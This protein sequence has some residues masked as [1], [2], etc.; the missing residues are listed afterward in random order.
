[1]N[2]SLKK[3]KTIKVLFNRNNSVI[4]LVKDN[5]Q[6]LF[7]IKKINSNTTSKDLTNEKSN[8]IIKKGNESYI[9]FEFKPELLTNPLFGPIYTPFSKE[10]NEIIS[11]KLKYACCSIFYGNIGIKEIMG[12]FIKFKINN[13]PIKKGLFINQIF[14][15]KLNIIN[16]KYENETYSIDISHGRKIYFSFK[17]NYTLIE[18]IDSDNIKDFLIYDEDINVNFDNINNFLLKEVIFLVF[19]TKK[20]YKNSI[21][22][23]V[24]KENKLF[25]NYKGS[26]I[27]NYNIN[28][29]QLDINEK[30]LVIIL[31]EK[32]K[33]FPLIDNYLIKN[34]I[35][36]DIKKQVKF[37][38]ISYKPSLNFED[39]KIIEKGN[40]KY[41][42]FLKDGNFSILTSDP[43]LLYNER[44]ISDTFENLD[45][46]FSYKVLSSDDL[47]IF[48]KN[49]KKAKI[50]RPNKFNV[51]KYET[52]QILDS[53]ISIDDIIE[54]K[55]YL[56]FCNTKDFL[57]IEM[58]KYNKKDNKYISIQKIIFYQY[59]SE[60]KDFLCLKL[61]LTEYKLIK[62]NTLCKMLKIK[63]NQLILKEGIKVWFFEIINDNIS[64][65]SVIKDDLE[66][67]PF[68]YKGK[69]LLTK[70]AN[71]LFDFK[72]KKSVATCSLNLS[73][74]G[75]CNKIILIPNGNLLIEYEDHF[76][77][78]KYLIEAIIF[79][80][81]IFA[82]HKIEIQKNHKLFSCL[83]NGKII[84]I[85]N[86]E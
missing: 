49:S 86:N 39:M 5:K 23:I 79:K 45:S 26:V 31:N 2:I 58:W 52:I 81:E 54:V 43:R 9:I 41:L 56:I 14:L 32:E 30:Y 16:Y 84:I 75:Y 47:L 46:D 64:L 4:R 77:N 20:Y 63:E 66:F 29:N 25:D 15:E 37:S 19:N 8:K 68:V 18:I 78:K 65:I 61:G 7:F 73:N 1:M 13:F 76:Y 38:L 36:E 57:S 67:C 11:S 6:Q 12:Y 22:N 85:D 70:Y 10:E 53:Q 55:D 34:D 80:K 82:I 17:Y 51:Q 69:Y 42:Q 72:L 62:N 48:Y 28:I 59:K 60:E 74:N 44:F 71:N 40:Y 50:K 83:K 35:I 21:I 27:I 3:Y 33:N 24:R